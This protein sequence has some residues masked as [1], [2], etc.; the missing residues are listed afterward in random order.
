M[1]NLLYIIWKTIVTLCKFNYYLIFL[2][3]YINSNLYYIQYDEK[4]RY[5][6]HMIMTKGFE[7]YE[8]INEII[9]SAS[10]MGFWQYEI[11]RYLNVRT[12]R[13][14]IQSNMIVSNAQHGISNNESIVKFNEIFT[15]SHI[16]RQNSTTQH[17]K[18]KV[19]NLDY[20]K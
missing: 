6:N 7:L 11:M 5:W 4:F 14:L 1:E 15:D 3:N 18:F 12:I 16:F 10:Y 2:F 20:V 17:S 13:A 19:N 8:R 9:K